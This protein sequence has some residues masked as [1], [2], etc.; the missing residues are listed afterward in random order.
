MKTALVYFHV[1]SLAAAFGATLIAEHLIFFRNGQFS[2][3]N[4]ETLIFAARTTR[5]SLV[6]LWLTGIG[7]VIVGYLADPQYIA[8]QK[9][10]A[11]V[12]IVLLMS[13]NGVYIHKRILPRFAELDN[14]ALL[15]RTTAESAR[16]R[17]AFATSL[18]G[19]LLTPFYGAAKF[20]NQ[21]YVYGELLGLYLVTVATIVIFSYLVP[22]QRVNHIHDG[23]TVSGAG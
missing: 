23:N 17:I 4:Y 5:A 7:L 19:W 22:D 8:N 12:S 21:G 20:L 1:L 10:W 18:S 9:I 14:G 6:L 2:R 3:D 16:M 13:I 11:K 15:I